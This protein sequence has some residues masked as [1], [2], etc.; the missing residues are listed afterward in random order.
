MRFLFWSVVVILFLALVNAVASWL[1]LDVASDGE[2]THETPHG[3]ASAG[4][5]APAPSHNPPH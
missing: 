4:H 1:G 5:P 3:H 2:D